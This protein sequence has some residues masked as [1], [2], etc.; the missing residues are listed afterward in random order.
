VST[1]DAIIVG[2][3]WISEHFFT[4]DA[5]SQSFLA[6]VLD[7]RKTWEAEAKEKRPTPRSRFTETRQKLEL[8][9]AGLAEITEP[10]ILAKTA[11]DVYDQVLDV[12]EL[13]GHGLHVAES[14]PV[15]RVSAPGIT[16]KAPLAV[17]LGSP[18]ATVEEAIAKNGAT[19]FAPHALVEEGEELT[20]A[21]RLVSALFV[22]EDAPE[23]VLLLAGRWAL[24]AEQS[25]W[26]EGRYLAVDLQLVCERNDGRRGG[27]I[28]RA[29]TCLSAQSI[30]PGADG[31][32][33]WHGVLEESVKH[34]V[35]VSK[36]LR[37]GVRLSIEIIANEVVARRRDQGLDALPAANA[38]DLAKQSLRFLYRILFLLY[39]EASPELGVLPVGAQTYDAGYSL[40]RL[41]DLVQV[42]LSTPQ[43]R[44]GTHLYSSL[45][46]LFRLVDS[47]HSPARAGDE[48]E[49][50]EG[51]VFNALRADLFSPEATRFID[52]VGLGNVA[53]QKVLGHLLLSK[54][55]RGK[56]RGFIS[57]AE[58]GINQLGAV[59]EGLM[60]YTGFFAGTGLY[61]VAKGGD[62][63]KGSW[64]V[65]VSRAEGIAPADFVKAEDPITGEKMPVL[66][67]QGSFVFRLSGR[68]RQQS[69]SYYTPEVL[70]KFT[71]GQ[72][73]EE[74]LDQDG[75]TTPA[76]DVLTV[77]VCEPAL[78]SGAFAI[79]AVRQLAEQYLQRRQDEL[80]ERID[81][82]EYP[83]R[84]QEVKAYLA[85]HNVY[86][87]DLNA[88]AVELAEISLWLDTMVSGLD[89]PWFGLHLRRG[90]S[91]IGARR[92]V[93]SRKQVADKA[94]LT[95]VPRDLPL[96]SFPD[97]IAADRVGSDLGDGIHHF[98]L[99]ADGWG[100]AADA[101]EA[102]GLV[103]DAVKALKRWR[104]ST[105]TKLTK[106]QLDA[107][108][109]L[110]SRVETLWQISYRRLQI[111]EQEIRRSIPVWGTKGLRVGGAVQREQ[112][113]E[114][115]ADEAGAYRRLRRV[116]DAWTAL[117]F[118]P[119][120]ESATTV[121]GQRVAP[122]TVDQ[123]IAGLRALLGRNPELSGTSRPKNKRT[124]GPGQMSLAAATSWDELGDAEALELDFAGARPID[125]V[126]A[127]HPWLVVCERVAKQQGFFHWSLDFAPAFARGG[128]DLQVGNPPWVRPDIDI[129]ALLAEGDPWWKL[130][131]KPS[132]TL[133]A[134]KRVETLDLLGISELVADGA[135]GVVCTAEFLRSTP[136]FPH[137]A[138]LRP[139]LYRCFMEQTWRIGS[140]R[141]TVGLIHLDTHFTDDKAGLLR[142]ETYRRLRRHWEF[143]NEL[144]LFEIQH[145]KHY[146]VNVYGRH[147][148]AVSFRN[149]VSLYHPDTVARSLVHDGSGAE[150]GFKDDDGNW[151]QRPHR[152][153]VTHVTDAVL[154]TWHAVLEGAATPVAQ[155]RMVYAINRATSSVLG[156]LARASRVGDL[157]LRFDQGWNE[158]TDRKK[159]YIESNWGAPESWDDVILQGPHLY[160]GT[161]LYKTPNKTMLHHLDWSAT[162]FEA[163]APDTVPVTAYKPNG[164]RY[165]Y[166]CDYTD[167]GDEDNPEPA[168][169]YYRIAWRAMAANT[170]E[171]TLIPAIIPPGAAHVHGVFSV[172]SPT[173]AHRIVVET[174]AFLGSLVNDFLIRAV[175]KSGI[176]KATLDRL[177][178]VPNS[179]LGELL[180]L[181]SLRLN[182][183]THAYADLWS[184]CW[185][186]AFVHDSWTGGLTHNRRTALESVTPTWT[187]DTPLRIAADRRQA[188]VEID[189]LVA[190]MLG[191]TAD[192]LC[193]IYRTQFAVL[194]GYDRTTY[195]YDAN[196]RLVPNS[197]LSV[198][199]KKG[200]RIT[201]DERTATN[202]AGNTYVYELP[203]VTLDREADMRQAYAEFEK[204]LAERS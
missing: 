4:T 159:G 27:E 147:R 93:Y 157:G 90:N 131:V 133:I 160:V 168:R 119:L 113:E 144:E 38:N 83:R 29:L 8:D 59:Y 64:V 177:S 120:T 193:T 182:S 9:L 88:T 139:D 199:R 188:L 112:I 50:D 74:L 66:H 170:G 132:Q 17:V 99:P 169:D 136:Q 146:G 156:K 173:A 196:G 80:G 44:S 73:L 154:A 43:S 16:E 63:E 145:Q 33:W 187:R 24:L 150:P 202:Q 155:T 10:E 201:A 126:L 143:I 81:P 106:A 122:P 65:P 167:W 172:G 91:L 176:L 204:R 96:T 102:A 162:D 54:E 124:A 78:G 110:A 5:T 137:L 85:L 69:A 56:D 181:R 7:R 14:G 185:T 48:A 37:E 179:T 15:L 197:V 20:S 53:L 57:Y 140:E 31:A 19:L 200:E 114:S 70:T 39:A 11:L 195:F 189:A 198:W 105:K 46:V 151:D 42:E 98:L 79:E 174:S 68:D 21:A 128:F 49:A 100:A 148:D 82:D 183:V 60:S 165:R 36:D 127:E 175:P 104:G 142:A 32:L 138:G 141:G 2:E 203:F 153:R 47:G 97:D 18:V 84:L 158:T 86:G 6:K 76:A 26:A 109:E 95:A 149:A 28:D 94:W 152:G 108:T 111:A 23:F 62:A 75:V 87:V 107:L 134:Q 135:A 67:Q 130:A 117:W 72:A 184:T 71:V 125:V 1:S 77:S 61:E 3:G 12:L 190:L 118:W 180:V 35:G 58:L 92:A 52:A 178:F 123:W 164:D 51:L 22:D 13:R 103:P 25:R 161:P 191:L 171:R 186:T 34:T 55:R 194:Y 89:A 45:G 115:L 40:D 129:D 101:K 166:D 41:R 116:M 121:D 192:E 30:A 163:L